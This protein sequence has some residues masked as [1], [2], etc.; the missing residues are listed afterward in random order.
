MKEGT[1]WR[2]E[3][4]VEQSGETI[5]LAVMVNLDIPGLVDMDNF[6]G[7]QRIGG[8]VTDCLVGVPKLSL[9]LGTSDGLAN[10]IW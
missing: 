7:E 5:E 2:V 1:R 10:C 4:G 6:L 3:D 9:C 8:M